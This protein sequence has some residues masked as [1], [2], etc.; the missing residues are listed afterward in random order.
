[1]GCGENEVL[2]HGGVVPLP[3]R[4]PQATFRRRSRRNLS[5]QL[6]VVR[7]NL[8]KYGNRAGG[9][10]AVDASR[11]CVIVNGVI[12]AAQI[13]ERLHH[14]SRFRI[15][16]DQLPGFILVSTSKFPSVRFDP[17]AYKQAMMDW[18]QTS[19]MR[20]WTTSDRPLGHDCALLEINDC[21]V[22]LTSYNVPHR[23][24]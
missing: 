17:A 5:D 14:F 8:L 16:Y 19:G 10:W 21:H 15:Y 23:D 11:C 4:H 20:H 22:A 9:P 12:G 3:F 7:V 13:V 18:V 6:E 1:M 2:G 24:V